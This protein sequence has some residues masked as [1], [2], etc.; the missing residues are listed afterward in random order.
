MVATQ[1]IDVDDIANVV[2]IPVMANMLGGLPLYSVDKDSPGVWI[3]PLDI[4]IKPEIEMEQLDMFSN[5]NFGYYKMDSEGNLV[6]IP[7]HSITKE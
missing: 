5:A 6:S 2:F 1:W 4:G 3:M 7:K